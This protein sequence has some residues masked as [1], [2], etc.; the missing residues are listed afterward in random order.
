MGPKQG[1]GDM[2]RTWIWWWGHGD[3]G[4]TLEE[5]VKVTADCG[6]DTEMANVTWR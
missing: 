5:M 3:G 1:V 4:G 2:E 6:G